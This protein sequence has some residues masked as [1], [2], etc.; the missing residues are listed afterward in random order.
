MRVLQ[1]DIGAAILDKKAKFK[2]PLLDRLLNLKRQRAEKVM[3]SCRDVMCELADLRIKLA[4]IESVL[5]GKKI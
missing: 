1:H 5:H 3:S 2:F 4:Q